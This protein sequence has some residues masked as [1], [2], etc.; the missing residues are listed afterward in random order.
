MDF[1]VRI[2]LAVYEVTAATGRPPTAAEVAARLDASVDA[3]ANAYDRLARSR[4]LVLESDGTTIRMAPPFSGVPTQHR[5]RSAGI[6]YHAN[7]AWD[8]L[9]IV[10]ALGRPATVTS[11]CE[12]TQQPLRLEVG[13]DGPDL[14]AVPDWRFHTPVPAA[15]WW[16]DIVFT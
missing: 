13:P 10:A 1:D 11:R 12:E 6:G 9:G 4:L 5:V 7:C 16:Q 15:R 8:A 14:S 2:K 3:V